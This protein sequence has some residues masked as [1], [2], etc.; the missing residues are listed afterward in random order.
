MKRRF[1][2][3][4]ASTILAISCLASGCASDSGSGVAAAR[5]GGDLPD[6]SV[7]NVGSGESVGLHSLLPG[8]R[9]L[10]VWFWAP[11]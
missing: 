1:V 6:V 9:P 7:T 2:G 4:A 10:L 5:P 11:Y 3:L 8:D